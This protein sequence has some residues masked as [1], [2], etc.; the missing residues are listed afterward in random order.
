VEASKQALSARCVVLSER[1]RRAERAVVKLVSL[2]VPSAT[3]PITDPTI[4]TEAESEI[5]TPRGRSKTA[6][7]EE[8]TAPASLFSKLEQQDRDIGELK[9]VLMLVHGSLEE[10]RE[11]NKL[12]KIQ[13]KALV[14]EL[15]RVREKEK[16]LAGLAAHTDTM[17]NAKT[18]MMKS[19][20]DMKACTA[21]TMATPTKSAMGGMEE[22]VSSSPISFSPSDVDSVVYSDSESSTTSNSG[23]LHS[24]SLAVRVPTPPPHPQVAQFGHTEIHV[25]VKGVRNVSWQVGLNPPETLK[26]MV[27]LNFVSS[28][29]TKSGSIALLDL[30]DGG[31]GGDGE[32]QGA[33]TAECTGVTAFHTAVCRSGDSW[34]GGKVALCDPSSSNGCFGADNGDPTMRFKLDM[35]LN[36][37]MAAVDTGKATIS[38]EVW[39]AEEVLLGRAVVGDED[40]FAAITRPSRAWYPLRLSTDMSEGDAEL[41][42]EYVKVEAPGLS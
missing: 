10:E 2:P 6:V 39:E 32:Q 25:Q 12:L 26:V 5:Q 27:K 20:E 41:Y 8:V 33:G 18:P 11:S 35:G 40:L 7:T 24:T 16:Y 9:R 19:A 3:K 31:G 22:V 21:Q 13:K 37:W 4:S 28:Q 29:L 34:V 38:V 23:V 42:L 14:K 1:L 30:E 15:R 17:R 36:H